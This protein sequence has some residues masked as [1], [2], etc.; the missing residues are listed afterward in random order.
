MLK[1]ISQ[2][3]DHRLA[4]SLLR[5]ID[6]DRKAAYLEILRQRR[7]AKLKEVPTLEQQQKQAVFEED[8]PFVAALDPAEHAILK[9]FEGKALEVNKYL[10]DHE[11]EFAAS[12]READWLDVYST[13]VKKQ[14]LN[15]DELIHRTRHPEK[16]AEDLHRGMTQE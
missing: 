7:E 9:Q 4:E 14:A 5:R 11:H 10:R 6:G 2:A 8:L 12:L 16:Y 15:M 13:A 3:R 1:Q